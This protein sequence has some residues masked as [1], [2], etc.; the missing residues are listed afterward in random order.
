[1]A[2]GEGRIASRRTV[3]GLLALS[4]VAFGTPALAQSGEGP[5]VPVQV[6]T[7]HA[8]EQGTTIDPGLE[9]LS[10]AFREGKLPYTSFKR[11]DSKTVKLRRGLPSVVKLPNARTATLT[12]KDLKDGTAR[13]GIQVSELTE[14]D[15]TLGRE[16]S[17]IQIGGEHEAGMIVLQLSPAK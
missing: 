2:T 14:A 8:T 1:M 4:L 15:V 16:G 10:R 3:F 13:L 17:V 11:L 5:E 9:K 7:V 6:E 12:L